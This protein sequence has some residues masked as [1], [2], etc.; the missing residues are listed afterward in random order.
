M[1]DLEASLRKLG[2]SASEVRVY[3]HLLDAGAGS[4]PSIAKGTGIARANCYHVLEALRTKGLISERHKGKRVQYFPKDPQAL[5]LT[6]E[7]RRTLIEDLLPDLR[8]LYGAS[9][10]KPQVHFY[11]GFEEVKS[12]YRRS[13]ETDSIKAFGS[14]KQLAALDALF[15]R[16]YFKEIKKRGIILRDILTIESKEELPQAQAILGALYEPVLLSEKY[17]NLL[18][19]ILLWDRHVAIITLKEP[20]FGTV[21]TSPELSKTFNAIHDALFEQLRVRG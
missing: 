19:D 1:S 6:L 13:L 15:F 7:N 10:N 5:L 16:D 17:K 20:I 18:T 12:I 4:P 2:L 9:N 21:L 3:L 14:T 8:A 11:E